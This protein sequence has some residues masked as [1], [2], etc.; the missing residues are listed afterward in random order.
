[1]INVNS[2]TF[3]RSKTDKTYWH[4]QYKWYY[5]CRDIHDKCGCDDSFCIRKNL[6]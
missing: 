6:L 4:K 2:I 3:I 5:T 1:M